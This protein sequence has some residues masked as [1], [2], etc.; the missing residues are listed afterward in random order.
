MRNQVA[1][2]CYAASANIAA[3]PDALIERLQGVR[4]NASLLHSRIMDSIEYGQE[5]F[6]DIVEKETRQE[7]EEDTE[8]KFDLTATENEKA[9]KEVHKIFLMSRLQ[10]DIYVDQIKPHIKTLIEDQLKK[11]Q[12]TRVIMTL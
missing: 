11:M 6:K 8:D 1:K 10:R 7:E 2:L 5:I 12:S 4:E 3:I 9:L